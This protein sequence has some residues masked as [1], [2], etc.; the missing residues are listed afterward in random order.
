MLIPPEYQTVWVPVSELAGLSV[1][2]KVPEDWRMQSVRDGFRRWL[3]GHGAPLPPIV[4]RRKRDC[5]CRPER[6]GHHVCGDLQGGH[7]RLNVA[8]EMNIPIRVAY[9]PIGDD[10]PPVFGWPAHLP[11]AELLKMGNPQLERLVNT[12]SQAS[13]NAIRSEMMACVERRQCSVYETFEQAA[14]NLFTPITES[15]SRGEL[16][17]LVSPIASHWEPRV[18]HVAEKAKRMPRDSALTAECLP[19]LVLM[20]DA[21]D[22]L[23]GALE[24]EKPEAGATF[25]HAIEPP[26]A[27]ANPPK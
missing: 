6:T 11:F 27:L 21:L 14:T 13:A 26:V 22:S 1:L 18:R 12:I 9:E 4:V 20:R 3:M 23:I 19:A 15:S 7:H 2:H 17:S 5:Q 8:R 10:R 25:M 16:C 24:G